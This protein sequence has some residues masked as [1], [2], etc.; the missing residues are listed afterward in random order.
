MK[1][2]VNGP[3]FRNS[4]KRVTRVNVKTSV[5]HDASKLRETQDG[6]MN[7]GLLKASLF[8]SVGIQP[9]RVDEKAIAYRRCERSLCVDCTTG[10]A[11]RFV[12]AEWR[13]FEARLRAFNEAEREREKEAAGASAS[14]R[15]DEEG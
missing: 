3:Q 4:V 11:V 6:L 7:G 15:A 8:A 9:R 10:A 1:R 13:A 12:R 5:T 14:P 2:L